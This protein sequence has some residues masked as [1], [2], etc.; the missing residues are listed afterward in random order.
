M[1]NRVNFKD[2]KN[3]KPLIW[4]LSIVGVGLAIYI[5]AT[6]TKKTTTNKS[7]LT[8]GT[9]GSIGNAI[10]SLFAPKATTTYTSTNPGTLYSS[11]QGVNVENTGANLWVA[12]P[13]GPGDSVEQATEATDSS[14][15]TLLTDN[16]NTVDFSNLG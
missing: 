6:L 14:D 15:S 12:P 3:T 2:M 7:I 4:G 5:V 8:P 10:S 13:V 16:G 9:I 11:S 1:L